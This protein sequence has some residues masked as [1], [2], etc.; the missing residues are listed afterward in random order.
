MSYES[1]T[2]GRVLPGNSDVLPVSYGDDSGLYVEFYLRAVLNEA[3]SAIEGRPIYEDREYVKMIPAGDK[4]KAADRPVKK[5]PYAGRP[6][7][8]LRFPRQ[9]EAFKNQNVKA[10][11]GTPIE[12]WGAITRSDA[13]MLKSLN[14]HTLEML[15]ELQENHLTWL[16]ARQ[17]RD[18]AKIAVEKAKDGAAAMQWA[19]EKS[20][21]QDQMQAL[22]NQING[23]R[24]AGVLQEASAPPAKRGPKP[25]VKNEQ[26]ILTINAASG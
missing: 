19:K 3:K 23:L 18:K 4:T 11:E 25:K 12:E 15:S 6:A 16:G 8:Q 7:D 24:D 20:D 9:W 14:I 17:M 21:M 2:T 22:Q 13:M 10:I 1:F 26:N 5:V